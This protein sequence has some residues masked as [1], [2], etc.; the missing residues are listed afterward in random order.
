M[1]Q[2]PRRDPSALVG[3]GH[4][5]VR[6]DVCMVSERSRLCGCLLMDEGRGP[7]HE[8][9]CLDIREEPARADLAAGGEGGRRGQPGDRHVVD[10]RGCV[11]PCVVHWGSDGCQ[12]VGIQGHQRQPRTVWGDSCVLHGRCQ[13]P[14]NIDDAVERAMQPSLHLLTHAPIKCPLSLLLPLPSPP[15]PH[16]E[17]AAAFSGGTK[18]GGASL[19]T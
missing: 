7:C 6:G 14:T 15:P 17:P 3:I 13:D 8:T 18:A 19:P 2:H 16:P 1:P 11:N 10:G 12:V 9:T 4:L 5:G